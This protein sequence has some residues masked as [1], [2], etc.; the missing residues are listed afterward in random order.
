MNYAELVQTLDSDQTK[1]GHAGTLDPL[2]TGLLML[3]TGK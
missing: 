1:I 2:A 3:C